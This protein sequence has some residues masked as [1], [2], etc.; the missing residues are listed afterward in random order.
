MCNLMGRHQ[1]ECNLEWI[2]NVECA[3]ANQA[4][5]SRADS[6]SGHGTSGPQETTELHGRGHFWRDHELFAPGDLCFLFSIHKLLFFFCLREVC[7]SGNCILPHAKE[8]FPLSPPLISLS[9][10]LSHSVSLSVSPSPPLPLSVS[11]EWWEKSLSRNSCVYEC[12]LVRQSHITRL[13]RIHMC[14]SVG[15]ATAIYIK[16]PRAGSTGAPSPPWLH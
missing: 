2:R 6:Q 4:P 9:L 7:L 12:C 11:L 8:M 13:W 14:L 16:E 10:S 1:S 5:Q 3:T 15:A